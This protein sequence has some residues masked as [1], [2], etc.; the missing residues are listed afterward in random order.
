MIS[1]HSRNLGSD[2]GMARLAHEDF[3]LTEHGRCCSSRGKGIA[4]QTDLVCV[5]LVA[6]DLLVTHHYDFVRV[7]VATGD[8]FVALDHDDFVRVFIHRGGLSR[9][10]VAASS[11]G[12]P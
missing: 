5:D 3:A 8:L 12:E 1:C 7:L 2:L 4:Q 6:G 10:C 11:A 9:L